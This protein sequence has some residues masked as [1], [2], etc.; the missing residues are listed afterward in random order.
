MV[1]QLINL[2]SWDWILIVY[3]N[4]GPDDILEILRTLQRFGCSN[5]YLERAKQNLSG[6]MLDTGLTY[7]NEEAHGTVMVISKASNPGEFWNTLDHEKGHAAKHI[8]EALG[9]AC[10]GEE[11]QYL[12]G[13]LAKEMYPIARNYIR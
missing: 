13:E 1:R 8:A 2:D 9:L 10:S 3:Y 4:A 5:Q 12:T 7:T 6:D 11:V